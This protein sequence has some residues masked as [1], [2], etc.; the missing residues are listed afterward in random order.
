MIPLVAALA[1]G[2]AATAHA[3][4]WSQQP[5]AYYAKIALNR[6]HATSDYGLD[7]NKQRK[8]GHGRLTDLTLSAYLEYG[9]R[10][11]LTLVAS[12]PFKRLEDQRSFAN[13]IGDGFERDTNFG[14]LELRLR[15]QLW[16][17]PVTVAGALGTKL[18]LGYKVR[19]LSNVPLGTGERDEDVRLLVGHS[20][21][22]FPG[23]L[24]GDLGWRRRGGS[25]SNEF[26]F[27]AEAGAAWKKALFKGTLSS[28]RTLGTCGALTQAGL[29]GDQDIVKLSPGLIFRLTERIELNLDL[30]HIATGC[31]TTAGTT[32]SLGAA[33]VP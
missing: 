27:T 12:A 25:F 11:R 32:W 33:L 5:G 2:W 15:Y 26:F 24:T 6:L 19:E 22:P 28:V 9:L 8:P 1:I 31:N 29:V 17:E 10:E 20:L 4:A 18:P 14:D 23:Y 3:G 7:G 21:H 13:N 30:F 16:E